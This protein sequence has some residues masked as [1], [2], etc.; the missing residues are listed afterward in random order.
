MEPSNS[1]PLKPCEAPPPLLDQPAFQV[2][3]GAETSPPFSSLRTSPGFSAPSK[4]WGHRRQRDPTQEPTQTTRPQRLWRRAGLT[5]QPSL[6]AQLG[7]QVRSGGAC[8]LSGLSRSDLVQPPAA[9]QARPRG[10]VP[11]GPPAWAGQARAATC[12]CRLRRTTSE[13]PGEAPGI[14]DLAWPVVLQQGTRQ[15]AAHEG[16]G[17]GTRA[18]PTSHAALHA[19]RQPHAPRQL[20]PGARSRHGETRRGE[21][22]PEPNA[23]TWPAGRLPEA[24]MS[25]GPPGVFWVRSP[26]WTLRGSGSV[27]L[28]GLWK[29]L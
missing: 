25:P 22:Q 13:R 4:A 11:S 15:H 28:P 6:P 17:L 21:A 26:P 20:G 8:G 19:G 5:F 1:S 9:R 27:L 14:S 16:L 24:S 29:V 23:G 3:S 7:E 18:L 2:S 10:A 12:A